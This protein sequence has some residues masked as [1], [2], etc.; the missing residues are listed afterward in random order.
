MI[1]VK[2]QLELERG[3]MEQVRNWPILSKI[4]I[5]NTEMNNAN[6]NVQIVT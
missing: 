1:R 4:P 5:A 6:D 2:I 3:D